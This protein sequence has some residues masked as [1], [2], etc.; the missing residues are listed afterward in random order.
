MG[1]LAISNKTLDKYFSFLKSL[2]NDAK[3]RLIIK[4]TKSLETKKRKDFDPKVLFGAW[5]DSRDSD[6]II[7][8]IKSSRVEKRNMESL[9]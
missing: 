5:K 3:K 9:G 4:L 2:N 7:M 8:E 1:S 6:E